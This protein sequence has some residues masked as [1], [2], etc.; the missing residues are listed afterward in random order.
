V[1]HISREDWRLRQDSNPLRPILRLALN[2]RE[3]V[4]ADVRKI[5]PKLTGKNFGNIYHSN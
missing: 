4:V 3:Q 5:V 2:G 1:V